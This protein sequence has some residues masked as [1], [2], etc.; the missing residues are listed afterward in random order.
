MPLCVEIQHDLEE[1]G[2]EPATVIDGE[3]SKADGPSVLT[4]ETINMQDCHPK[5]HPRLKESAVDL[6]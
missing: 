4:I 2:D 3:Q 1:T 6:L 5:S